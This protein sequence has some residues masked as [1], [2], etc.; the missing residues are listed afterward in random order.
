MDK[1]RENELLELAI[2]LVSGRKAF[3]IKWREN[4][5]DQFEIFLEPMS[6][7]DRR[8]RSERIR[9]VLCRGISAEYFAIEWLDTLSQC[10]GEIPRETEQLLRQDGRLPRDGKRIN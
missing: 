2:Q 6:E 10:T 1:K 4:G 9:E 3:E 7:T 8:I 5:R